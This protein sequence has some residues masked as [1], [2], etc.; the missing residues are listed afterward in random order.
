MK[1]NLRFNK[2]VENSSSLFDET[3]FIF[4]Y[5]DYRAGRLEIKLSLKVC[6]KPLLVVTTDLEHS[7]SQNLSEKV[8]IRLCHD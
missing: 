2:V 4:M 3:S 8:L 6:R 5:T 7:V 1:D